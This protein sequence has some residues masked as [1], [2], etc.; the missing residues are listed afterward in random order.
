MSHH[1]W[2]LIPMSYPYLSISFLSLSYLSLQY[3]HIEHWWIIISR[4]THSVDNIRIVSFGNIIK[5]NKY[6]RRKQHYA[7]RVRRVNFASSWI[8][9][10]PYIRHAL[11]WIVPDDLRGYLIRTLT[12]VGKL[13]FKR[14]LFR[15][16]ASTITRAMN[17]QD[18]GYTTILYNA[19]QFHRNRLQRPFGKFDTVP[20]RYRGSGHES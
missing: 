11:T 4:F 15:Y 3:T 14:V 17:P 9:R 2:K 20:H 18:A 5:S 7:H 10:Y 1:I 12:A 8:F 19:T 13:S 16:I 6:V